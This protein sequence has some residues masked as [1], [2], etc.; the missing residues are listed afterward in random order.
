MQ[1]YYQYGCAGHKDRGSSVC[2]NS[3]KVSR[4][5]AEEKLLAGIQRDLFTHEGL[6]L[7]VKETTRLLAERNRQ[8]QPDRERAELRLTEVEKELANIMKAITAGIFTAST[9]AELEKKEAER[10]RLQ[11]TIVAARR[12][13]IRS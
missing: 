7:F 11:Q 9:K 6:D 1:S 10:D 12:R 8:R 2:G 4:A 3:L 13:R 5:L